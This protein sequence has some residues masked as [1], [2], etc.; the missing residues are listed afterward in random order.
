MTIKFSYDKDRSSGQDGPKIKPLHTAF[1]SQCITGMD[2]CLRKQLIVTTSHLYINIWNY[3]TKS[4]EISHRCQQTDEPAAVA[5]HPSGFHIV[6]AFG[7]KIVCMNVLSSTL[8]EYSPQLQLKGCK[9]IRFSNGGHMFAAAVNLG[10]IHIYNFYTQECP[11]NMTTKGHNAKVR[12]IDWYEDDM[13]FT[14]CGMDGF[15]FFYDL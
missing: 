3:A 5:F 12:C 14:S 15:C 2:I 11:T 9:E 8:K 6:V 10:A 7:D 1:H 4:L 13:G